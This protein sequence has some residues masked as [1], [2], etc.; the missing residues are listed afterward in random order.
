MDLNTAHSQSKLRYLLAGL[1]ICLFAILL[2]GCGASSGQAADVVT[3]KA[4]NMQFD[5]KTITVKAGQAVTL[6]LE[7]DDSIAHG[8]AI[9]AI[10]VRTPQVAP[11]QSASV[12]FTP[13]QTGSFPFR[14]F[15]DGHADLGM[16][17]TFVVTP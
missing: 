3:V 10:H 15:V 11:G 4:N 5:V 2:S 13:T 17:G 16:V 1:V 6:K 8:I 9:D 7:N 12:T 14:C